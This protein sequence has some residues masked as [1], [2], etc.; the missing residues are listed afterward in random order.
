MTTYFSESAMSNS[1][2]KHSRPPWKCDQSGVP[3]APGNYDARGAN[4]L[5][6]VVRDQFTRAVVITDY[7]AREHDEPL[8]LSAGGEL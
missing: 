3:S 8:E 7:C 4:V 1:Q 6:Q 2:R 5:T